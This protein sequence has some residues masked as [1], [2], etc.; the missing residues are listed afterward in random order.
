M[1]LNSQLKKNIQTLWVWLPNVLK[2]YSIFVFDYLMK[3]PGYLHGGFSASIVDMVSSMA[4]LTHP[5]HNAGV[6]VNLSVS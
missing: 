3:F 6:S 2:L 4:L 5:K 1:K